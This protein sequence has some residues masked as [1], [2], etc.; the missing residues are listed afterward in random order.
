MHDS[1]GEVGPQLGS[2][3]INRCGCA[4]TMCHQA[5]GV[6]LCASVFQALELADERSEPSPALRMPT[7]GAGKERNLIPGV[8]D[9]PLTF[10]HSSSVPYRFLSLEVFALLEEGIPSNLSS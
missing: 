1:G 5:Q 6:L 9:R 4:P 10:P 8:W 2:Q 7:C 3:A